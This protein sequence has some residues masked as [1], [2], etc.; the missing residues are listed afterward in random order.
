MAVR[1]EGAKFWRYEFRIGGKKFKYGLGN[2]PEISLTNARKILA[3]ARELVEFGQHPATLLDNS[4]AMQM[5]IS[6]CSIKEIKAKAVTNK[7]LEL[8][9]TLMTFG[10]A[11]EKYKT[12]WV[13]KK[14]K[15]PDRGWSPVKLHL[16]PKLA[17]TPLEAMDVN[18]VR[19]LIYNIRENKGIAIAL[20]CHGW[21]DRI[22]SYAVEHDFCK[23]NPAALIKAARVGTRNKR[24]CWLST[25][26]IKRY[27]TVKLLSRL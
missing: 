6:G 21:A 12:N 18:M 10:D 9:E 17:D 20:L 1:A 2:Y 19:E 13:D 16:L 23:H 4:G 8:L 11:A 3:V 15:D 25:P 22:F 7:D 14:W 24:T 26:E 5:I 27:L